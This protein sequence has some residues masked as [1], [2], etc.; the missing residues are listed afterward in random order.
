MRLPLT[1]NVSIEDAR[2]KGYQC[3]RDGPNTTNCHFSIFAT[4]EMTTAWEE[5]NRRGLAERERRKARE[6]RK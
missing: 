5:G 1:S 2:Q 4:R 6:A 3:G